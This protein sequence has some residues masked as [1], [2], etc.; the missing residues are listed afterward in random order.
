MNILLTAF[1]GTSSETLIRQFDDEYD[2]L[3]LPNDKSESI[4]QFIR[5]VE[6]KNTVSFSASVKS[7]SSKTRY[8]SSFVAGWAVLPTKLLSM[9]PALRIPFLPLAFQSNSPA[10]PG[11]LSAI[12]CMRTDYGI[13]RRASTVRRWFFFMFPSGKILGQSLNPCDLGL[14]VYPVRL[15]SKSFKKKYSSSGYP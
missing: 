14:L 9:R 13:S 1:Q 6:S 8:I 3:T 15:M 11:L 2:K 12:I 7:P 10:T 5:A 4:G